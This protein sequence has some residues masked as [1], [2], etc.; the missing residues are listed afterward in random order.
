MATFKQYDK[1][2]GSKAWQFQS[3]LGIN[4]ATRKPVK[5]TRRGFK[6][7]KEAQLA[8]SQLKID[9]EKEGLQRSHNET[10]K[11]VYESWFETYGTTVKEVTKIKTKIQFDKWILPKYGELRINEITVKQAQ[12]IMNAWVKKT[13]QYK[14]LQSTTSRVFRYAI[15]LGII[16]N[17][18]LERIIMP[19]KETTKK[20]T[21][22]VYSK[23][24]LSKLFA[25]LNGLESNYR[26][27]YDYTLIRLLFYSGVRI[28][29][30]L[31][32]EWKDIDFE[33]NQITIN[34]TLS[35]SE[36][37]FKVSSPKNDTSISKLTIDKMTMKELK[38]W[39]LNQKKYM[40]AVGV[41]EPF[42]IFSGIYKEMINHHAIYRRFQAITK[43]AGIPFLGIHVTRHTHAS[44][45]LESGATM[46]EVQ[47]RLR[48]SSI[49]MTM[50]IYSH[51]SQESKE[52]TV[53]N[54]VNY[55][56]GIQYGIQ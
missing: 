29:E 24:E 1:K 47:T 6:T 45:L 20:D 16:A 15:N 32:L 12:Q 7:K 41:T 33:N 40:F 3:Y 42:F 13:S 55:V 56:N 4:Q 8:L 22:K 34:K 43:H 27:E 28:S 23:E 50:D 37:G 39:R 2:D 17:N 48:H 51:L 49:K 30:A 14:L 18:P 21:M 5:T 46:K 31:A 26:N 54:F 25:Y 11:E 10:F 19:K 38:K 35:Q 36:K 52:K 53:E 9:F 44:L